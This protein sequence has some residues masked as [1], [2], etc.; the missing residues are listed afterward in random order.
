MALVAF[1]LIAV[2]ACAGGQSGT[3]SGGGFEATGGSDPVGAKDCSKDADCDYLEQGLGQPVWSD[4]TLL[5]AH[6]GH[7]DPGMGPLPTCSCRILVTPANGSSAFETGLYPGHRLDAEGSG[8]SVFGRTPGCA[9]C[10]NE[11]PGCSVDDADE[12]CTGICDALLAQELSSYR[13]PL[14]AETRVARCTSDWTC[15]T[16]T[17]IEGKC[18]VGEPPVDGRGYD[19]AL[20]DQELFALGD[21][22]YER[23]CDPFPEVPCTEASECPR[24]LACVN[25]SCEAC[26][27]DDVCATGERCLDGFCLLETLIGCASA[28]DCNAAEDCV[29]S[30]L[31]LTQ[32]RGNEDSRAFCQVDPR[33]GCDP[34]GGWTPAC[35]P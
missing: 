27:S 25:G 19:C 16:I 24:A 33:V 29:W 26:R 3:E 31:D 35:I 20:S 28:S 4:A 18:Y 17:E 1:A 7:L 5:S 11:F 10:A 14:D 2:G 8:C 13:E 15:E 34:D 32:G 6:C 22:S 12:T 30:G 21:S 23:A 9:Y